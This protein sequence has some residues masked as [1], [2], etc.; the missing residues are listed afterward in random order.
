MAPKQA[1]VQKMHHVFAKAVAQRPVCTWVTSFLI[2]S[3]LQLGWIPAVREAFGIELGK[4]VAKAL[5]KKYFEE[6]WSSNNGDFPADEGVRRWKQKRNRDWEQSQHAVMFLGKDALEGQDILT[7]QVF[8]EMTPLVKKFRALNVTVNNRTFNSWDLCARGALPDKPKNLLSCQAMQAD[9]ATGCMATQSQLAPFGS[10]NMT[11]ITGC[12][13]TGEIGGP[14]L[15]PCAISAP[16]TCFS[17]FATEMDG[18][19]PSYLASYDP[20]IDVIPQFAPSMGSPWTGARGRP[21]YRSLSDA[22]IKEEV[23]KQR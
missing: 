15:F 18:V 17:E 19:H 13:A 21:S 12:M 7:A 8:D 22:Q 5:S 23:S 3:L 4:G 16:Q 10:C 9:M 1:V 14:P 20:Q 6:L 11:F 2:F